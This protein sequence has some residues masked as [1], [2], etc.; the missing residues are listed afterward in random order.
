MRD[1]TED[2]LAAKLLAEQPAL[3]F[4]SGPAA[5]WP[6]RRAAIEAAD[7]DYVAA[8]EDQLPRGRVREVLAHATVPLAP[9]IAGETVSAINPVLAAWLLLGYTRI[10]SR[11]RLQKSEKFAAELARAVELA[12]R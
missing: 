8:T 12:G 7:G 3:W 4:F 11:E 2:F 6:N 5:S 10:N 1:P 9:A